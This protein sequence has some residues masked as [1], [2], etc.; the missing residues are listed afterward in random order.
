MELPVGRTE[1]TPLSCEILD[2][3]K[4][5]LKKMIRRQKTRSAGKKTKGRSDINKT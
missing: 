3:T 5:A 1:A 4:N 2:W